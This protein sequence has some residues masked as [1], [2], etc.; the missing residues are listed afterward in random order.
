M[1][2]IDRR[3]LSTTVP[4]STEDSAERAAYHIL[5]DVLRAGWEDELAGGDPLALHRAVAKVFMLERMIGAHHLAPTRAYL[6]AWDDFQAKMA[7][8]NEPQQD[9]VVNFNAPML[10][11]VVGEAS[12]A[13]K[14]KDGKADKKA[15]KGAGSTSSAG[16]SFCVVCGRRSH[17]REAC[18]TE[19]PELAPSNLRA[20]FQSAHDAWVAAGSKLVASGSTAAAAAA[21]ASK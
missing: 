6:K 2:D 16:R 7:T 8:Q 15:K 12:H 21:A 18:Y 4:S 17:T 13:A 1:R 11:T 10:L 14:A 19:H 20:Q 3:L 5:C 9:F